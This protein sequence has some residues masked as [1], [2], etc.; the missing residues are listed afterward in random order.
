M[1]RA[2]AETN[3]RR[4]I[5][6]QYNMDNNITPESIIKPID[7]TMVAIAEADYVDFRKKCPMRL[8]RADPE[9]LA[10]AIRRLEDGN[11]GGGSKIRIRT[12][13][14]AS[15]QSSLP[16]GQTRVTNL[17]DVSYSICGNDG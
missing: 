14:A 8:T 5:Q 11:A 6:E 10:E 12:G 13:R 9:K 2:I 16:S 7:M 3:R 1:K 15:R 17:Q 4:E